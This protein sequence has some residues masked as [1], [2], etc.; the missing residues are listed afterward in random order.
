MVTG[1][2]NTMPAFGT[3]LDDSGLA[4]VTAWVLELVRQ[5]REAESR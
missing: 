1:G 4:N 3:M 5:A 2:S